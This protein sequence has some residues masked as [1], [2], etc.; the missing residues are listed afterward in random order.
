MKLVEE[1]KDICAAKG[2][3]HCYSGPVVLYCVWGQMCRLLAAVEGSVLGRSLA[4]RAVCCWY[5][6][7]LDGAFAD[8]KQPAIVCFKYRLQITKWPHKGGARNGAK[9]G[10]MGIIHHARLIKYSELTGCLMCA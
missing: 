4:F 9:L 10:S 5:N 1:K 6:G 8:S 2:G 3:H 7:M